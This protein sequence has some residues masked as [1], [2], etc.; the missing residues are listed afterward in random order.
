MISWKGRFIGLHQ[1]TPPEETN[2]TGVARTSHLRGGDKAAGGNI[3][4]LD[5]HVVWRPIEE[6]AIRGGPNDLWF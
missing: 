3:L 2:K 5:G 6:M 4:F 1:V